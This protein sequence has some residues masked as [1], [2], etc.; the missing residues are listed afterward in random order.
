MKAWITHDGCLTV[1]GET[2]LENYALSRWCIEWDEKRSR[3]GILLPA[4]NRHS[5]VTPKI[6]ETGEYVNM[7]NKEDV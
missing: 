7:V 3:L 5:K 1:E 6:V 4:P 2:E